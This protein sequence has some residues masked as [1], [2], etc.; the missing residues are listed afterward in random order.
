[1]SLPRA[2]DGQFLPPQYRL[3]SVRA[4]D[5]KAGD[6][7]SW[8]RYG[9][10][11]VCRVRMASLLPNGRMALVIEDPRYATGQ[12]SVVHFDTTVNKVEVLR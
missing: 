4:G 8:N 5:L 10:A 2:A 6:V 7:V 12:L 3:D 1:M 9:R 11:D